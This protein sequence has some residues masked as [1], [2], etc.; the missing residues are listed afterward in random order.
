MSFSAFQ[1]LWRRWRLFSRKGKFVFIGCFIFGAGLVYWNS[2]HR[3]PEYELT[4]ASYASI[5][6]LV[7]E[8]GH[9]T[10]AG[11]VPV[12]ST[13]TGM[14]DAVYVK[15]GDMVESNQKLF[16]VKSTASWQERDS[17]Y[18]A[19]L[20]AKS[21]L[22]AARANQLGLQAAMFNSWDSFK[23]LAESDEY[24]EGD[25]TPKYNERGV[26]E[27]HI[28]EK[29]WLAAEA[30]YK[31]QQQVISQAS[32]HVSATWKAYQATQDSTV[33]AILGGEVRNLGVARGDVV[34]VPTTLATTNLIP[35][36]IVLDPEVVPMIQLI[37]G[38][39]DINKLM[40]GQEAEIELDGIPGP[41]FEGVVDRVDTIS[42]PT[43]GLVSYSVYIRLNAADNQIR[44]GMSADVDIIVAQK[45]GV[46]TVPSSAIKP[47]QG[48]KAVR[49]VG[50]NEEIVFLPVTIGAKG[51]GL[52]EIVSGIEEGQEVIVALKN[53]QIER[54]GGLF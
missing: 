13:T 49:V 25:G 29:Q 46:L 23:A 52:T 47:Y 19:Y 8:T 33:V 17:A 10:T 22:E 54:G 45:D 50:E 28:P 16:S 32:V 48:G 6:E 42:A 37:V 21:T 51:D 53:D 30:A 24:E 7:S 3:Q 39:S 34:A 1:W 26:A 2:W 41:T 31:N 5:V 43:E 18:A 4:P 44:S 27:F 35:A 12:Y 15:N 36:M 9:V 11:A 38:E 20:S 14:V 40:E